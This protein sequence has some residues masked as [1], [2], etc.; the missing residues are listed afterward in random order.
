MSVTVE[1]SYDMSKALGERRLAIPNPGRVREVIAEV[2]RVFAEKGADFSALSK[3]TSIA[4]NGVLMNHRR[5]M[6]TKLE[7]GDVVAFVK[8]A[9]GG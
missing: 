6:K 9:S 7:D 8:A 3:V 5:G 4:I 1:F 2:E